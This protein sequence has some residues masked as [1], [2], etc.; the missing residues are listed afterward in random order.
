VSTDHY[1]QTIEEYAQSIA[2]VERERAYKIARAEGSEW[3]AKAEALAAWKTLHQGE[4]TS[5][6]NE[7][8]RLLD[9]D[10]EEILTDDPWCTP[11]EEKELLLEDIAEAIDAWRT[12]LDEL[13]ILVGD[14]YMRDTKGPC[15]RIIN[16]LQRRM[17]MWA[18]FMASPPPL[19]IDVSQETAH[20]IAH[21]TSHSEELSHDQLCRNPTCRIRGAASS[22]KGDEG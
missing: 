10:K 6:N 9:R 15:M 11:D 18:D 2:I 1:N 20:A 19:P 8:V 5:L 21:G 12:K 22:A 4:V 14:I 7:I 17:K 13:E 16:G 3:Q